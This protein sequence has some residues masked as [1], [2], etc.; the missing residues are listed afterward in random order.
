MRLD[1][2]ALKALNLVATSDGPSIRF[3]SCLFGIVDGLVPFVRLTAFSD[4]NQK[5]NLATLLDE[6]RTAMGSVRAIDT[7]NRKIM[8]FQ[9]IV[10]V[11]EIVASNDQAAVVRCCESMYFFFFFFSTQTY[12]LNAIFRSQY[13]KTLWLHSTTT[14]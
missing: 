14:H 12:M 5:M 11:A 6:T 9:R 2:A 4:V 3:D 8:I 13:V 1:A 7:K 10:N